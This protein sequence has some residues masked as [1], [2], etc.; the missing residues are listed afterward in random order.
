MN[1][2]ILNWH[3]MNEHKG[4]GEMAQHFVTLAVLAENCT[5]TH[6]GANNHLL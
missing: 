1:P 6:M 5:H 2:C 4:A 3:L